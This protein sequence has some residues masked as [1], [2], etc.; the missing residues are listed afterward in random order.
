[1]GVAAH[2]S[3]LLGLA[4]LSP[5]QRGLVLWA[6][7]AIGGFVAIIVVAQT[8]ARWRERMSTRRR[9]P[10]KHAWTEAARRMETP[11]ADDLEPDAPGEERD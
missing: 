9:R 5:L 10:I 2:I 1:M 7:V 6:L 11:T 8:A 3:A 4:A